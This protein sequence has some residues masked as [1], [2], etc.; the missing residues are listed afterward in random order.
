VTIQY[1]DMRYQF[2]IYK[3]RAVRRRLPDIGREIMIGNR[4]Y[5]G[6]KRIQ[7]GEIG[8]E[9]II[10]LVTRNIHD[11]RMNDLATGESNERNYFWYS[12]LYP[13]AR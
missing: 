6:G 13:L 12:I 11:K 4:G 10:A 8:R 9:N 1:V 7:Q 5:E 3:K 2:D